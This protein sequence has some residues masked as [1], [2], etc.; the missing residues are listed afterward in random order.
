MNLHLV[1]VPLLKDFSFDVATIAKKSK[2]TKMVVFPNPNNPTG[3]VIQIE[4]I[5]EIAR[6]C[7]G[8]V[9]V[10]EAYYEFYGKT[11]Q[12]LIREFKNV[13]IVRTFSK[14]MGMAGLRLGYALGD[15]Q[16]VRELGK[17]KLPFSVGTMQQTAGEVILDHPDIIESQVSRI[18][19]EKERVYNVLYKTNHLEIIPSF[20][21]F[22][23]FRSKGKTAKELFR[24]FC[25]K[26]VLLRTF[27]S[28]ELRNW[29][30]ITIGTP[31]ENDLFLNTLIKVMEE[32]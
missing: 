26:G 5:R 2:D 6:F 16:L 24:F 9:V 31:R 30:R 15:S 10:D 28:P 27:D 32:R 4:A 3:T 19:K 7:K 11:A 13:I 29:L 25:K 8:F 14:A 1:E 22:F 23:L 20:A 21:N 18:L 12:H 17:A